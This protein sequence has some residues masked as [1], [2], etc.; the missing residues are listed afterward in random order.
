MEKI[1]NDVKK[2]NEEIEFYRRELQE[3]EP[4]VLMSSLRR[5]S[6]MP[7][8]LEEEDQTTREVKANKKKLMEEMVASRRKK[9]SGIDDND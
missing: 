4:D 1:H 2:K 3:N 6:L 8:E 9:Q 7:A 5:T